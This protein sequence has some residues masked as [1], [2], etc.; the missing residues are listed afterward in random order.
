MFPRSHDVKF[1]LTVLPSIV[2][3][4][5]VGRWNIVR[6]KPGKTHKEE[7]DIRLF[8]IHPKSPLTEDTIPA[9]KT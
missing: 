8:Q 5:D 9:A 2:N 4:C 6:V 3:G 1:R 7:R